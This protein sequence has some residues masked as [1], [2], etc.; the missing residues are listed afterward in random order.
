MFEIAK[1]ANGFGSIPEDT[2]CTHLDN[3]FAAFKMQPQINTTGSLLAMAF[4]VNRVDVAQ[5]IGSL[6]A[7]NVAHW[8]EPLVLQPYEDPVLVEDANNAFMKS[9]K[10]MMQRPRQMQWFF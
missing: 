4:S 7:R 6:L 8:L 2:C 10:T 5:Y 9:F 1:K 3:Y